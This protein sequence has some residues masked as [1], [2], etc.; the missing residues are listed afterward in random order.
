MVFL[1]ALTG[2]GVHRL[3]PILVTVHAAFA[4]QVA[5][6]E[7]NRVLH[8]AWQRNPPAVPGKAEPKLFYGVQVQ[9]GPPAFVLHT[10]FS[11]GLH[12]SY[13]RFLE[14]T[15][16]DAFHLAGVPIRVMIRGRKH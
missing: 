16:R 2:T 15:L 1:S 8:E 5:T 10:N 7:L 13:Q 12:F 9:Y 4:S 3:F 6:A 14:N 11:S